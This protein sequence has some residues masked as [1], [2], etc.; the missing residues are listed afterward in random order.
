MQVRARATKS[1]E[2]SEL[3]HGV[4][5]PAMRAVAGELPCLLHL[6]EEIRGA[7]SIYIQQLSAF[8]VADAAMRLHVGEDLPFLMG[9]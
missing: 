1:G 6:A 8:S 9:L 5:S 3:E 2:K 4:S 7:G